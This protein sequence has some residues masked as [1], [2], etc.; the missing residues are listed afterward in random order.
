MNNDICSA[1]ENKL[2]LNLYYGGGNRKVEP[3]CYGVSK[4]G[5]EVL[6]AYQTSGYSGSG[7]YNGWKLF[8]IS[9]IRNME[10]TSEKFDGNRLKYNPND[11]RMTTIHCH[12]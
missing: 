10:V 5:N 1:I 11:S 4:A 12:V 3:F 7:N 9:E 2:V 8:L 6:S